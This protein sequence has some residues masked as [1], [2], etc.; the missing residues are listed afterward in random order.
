MTGFIDFIGGTPAN[1]VNAAAKTLNPAGVR[2]GGTFAGP[3]GLTLA[4]DNAGAILSSCGKLVSESRNY[5]VTKRGAQLQVE[6]ANTPKPLVIVLGPNNAFAGPATQTI[7]GRVIVG[8][9]TQV[10]EQRYVLDNTV[11]PGS[12]QEIQVPIYESRTANCGFASLRAT[13][14]AETE[15]S[16]TGLL[17]QILGG[18]GDPA[19]QRSGTATAPAGPRM[20]G[21]YAGG[22]FKVEFRTTSAILDCGQAHVMRPYDVQNLA[23]RVVVTVRNGNTPLTLTLRPDGTLAGSGFVDVNGRLVTGVN[24]NTGEVTFRPHSERC[25]VGTLAAAR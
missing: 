15:T 20:G 18:Q 16:V 22:N 9:Q 8:Y 2:I 1:L 25:A 17:S 11:V 4:F 6:I 7:T 10:R 3:A 12:R 14:A 19:A 13:A 24:D 23:D 5:T 21:T